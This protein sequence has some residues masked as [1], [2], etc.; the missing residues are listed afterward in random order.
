MNKKGLA[1]LMRTRMRPTPTTP[2]DPTKLA[3]SPI[4]VSLSFSL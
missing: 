4:N 2:N 3:T 1:I